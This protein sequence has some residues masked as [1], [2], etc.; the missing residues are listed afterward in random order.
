MKIRVCQ[1]RTEDDFDGTVQ[2]YEQMVGRI[3]NNNI[4][5]T[6]VCFRDE[7]TFY[8]NRLIKVLVME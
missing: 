4:L 2:F 8:L 6:N 1:E 7:C 5:A 3:N